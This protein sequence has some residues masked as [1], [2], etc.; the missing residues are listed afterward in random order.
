M[1]RK[2]LAPFG[3][4]LAKRIM[5]GLSDKVAI[6]FMG[7]HSLDRAKDFQAILP[8]TLALPPG[9]SPYRYNWMLTEYD[10]YLVDTAESNQSFVKT[11]ATCFLGHGANHVR[12][13][14]RS[15]ILN[16]KRRFV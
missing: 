16:F 11:C 1:Q 10:V 13:I 7:T 9:E 14:S 6:I 2:V 5:E 12:Y 15:S 3:E 8:Y 4:Y